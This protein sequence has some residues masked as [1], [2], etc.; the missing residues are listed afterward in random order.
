[1]LNKNNN[2]NAEYQKFVNDV[3]ADGSGY[4]NDNGDVMVRVDC[5]DDEVVEIDA[6]DICGL[7]FVNIID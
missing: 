4:V 5:Y 2:L 7:N 3:L 6:K 1:M